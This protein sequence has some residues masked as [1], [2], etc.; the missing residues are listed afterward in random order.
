M[1]VLSILFECCH[2]LCFRI[3]IFEYVYEY[4]L[5]ALL[6]IESWLLIDSRAGT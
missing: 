2:T 3:M 1:S 6:L 5:L 4:V